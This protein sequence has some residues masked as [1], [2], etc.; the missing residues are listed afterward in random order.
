MTIRVLVVNLNNKE[1]TKNC[2]NYLLNQTYSNFKVVVVDQNSSEDGTKEMLGNITD[3]RVEIVENPENIPLNHVWNWF[4]LNYNDD[5][6]C[7]LNNDVIITDN[8]ISDVVDV[9]SKELNVGIVVHSTNHENY[10]EKKSEIEYSIVERGKYM[11]GWDF[12]IRRSLYTL[13]PEEI[14]TYCGDDFLY[15]HLYQNGYDMAITTSSPMIHFEGQSKKYMKTS[16]VEDI[17]TYIGMGYPHYLK[18]NQDFSRIKPSTMF[19]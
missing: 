8:F 6:L 7:F 18:I 11:Q 3:P 9:F 13:I 19:L 15:H 1:Y 14:K 12:S 2:V 10:T 4:Y 17:H 5:I 16:G